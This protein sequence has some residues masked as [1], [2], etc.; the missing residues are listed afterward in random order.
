MK[1]FRSIWK[2][3]ANAKEVDIFHTIEYAIIRAVNVKTNGNRVEIARSLATPKEL[4][5][6]HEQ[7]EA[8]KQLQ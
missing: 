8:D 1:D 6:Y 4:L 3:L 7:K 5:S 2:T